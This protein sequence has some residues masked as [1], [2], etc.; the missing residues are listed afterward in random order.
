[1]TPTER[2]A[3][4][5][6]DV[7]DLSFSEVAEAISQEEATCRQLAARARQRLLALGPRFTPPPGDAK[8]LV[9]S[10]LYAVATG[11]L[12]SVKS[13]L[14]EDAVMYSDGGGKVQAALK[15]VE[16]A[17]RI[18]RFFVG[19]RA[20]YPSVRVAFRAVWV[21]GLP[22]IVLYREGE[23][24]QVLAFQFDPTGAIEAIYVTRN[25]EKLAHTS[26]R[27]GGAPIDAR[28]PA[29]LSK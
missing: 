9:E 12:G 4:L 3:F 21:N 18:S 13:L 16:G 10:F 15:P 20:K 1:M 27:P 11:D 26:L 8:R 28:G 6:H 14:S 2:A 7:F 29:P 24:D 25:P 23:L 22:G 5:L 17:D 19:I